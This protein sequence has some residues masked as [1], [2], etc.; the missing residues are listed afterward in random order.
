MLS[1]LMI[2]AVGFT[3][4]HASAET[5]THFLVIKKTDHGLHHMP[6]GSSIFVSDA[7]I[8]KVCN[9]KTLGSVM[10]NITTD[11]AS[12]DKKILQPDQCVKVTVGTPQLPNG[13][14]TVSSSPAAI[15]IDGFS[16]FEQA[17]SLFNFK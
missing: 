1:I 17:G 7:G 8:V 14:F 6:S 3:D 2:I 13:D 10:L 16:I 5:T 12:S 9:D 11:G 15:K 4:V